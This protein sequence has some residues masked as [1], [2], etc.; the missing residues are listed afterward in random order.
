MNARERAKTRHDAQIRHDAQRLADHIAHEIIDLIREKHPKSHPA[1][2]FTALAAAQASLIVL[3]AKGDAEALAGT[4][5]VYR[6]LRTDVIGMLRT[7]R[8]RDGQTP[9]A[10]S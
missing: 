3:F 5:M 7:K 4:E 1:V 8:E 2:V 9:Q 10:A 6:S